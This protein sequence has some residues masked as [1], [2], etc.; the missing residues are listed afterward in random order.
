VAPQPRFPSWFLVVTSTR[1]SPKS[2]RVVVVGGG[3]AGLTAALELAEG[4]W[5]V[6]LLEARQKLGGRASS[7]EDDSSTD[8]VDLCQ[9]VA[10]GACTHT[11]ELFERIGAND[12]F[13]RE[14]VIHFVDET[15]TRT[16]FAGSTWLP[17][18]LH[19]GRAFQGLKFLSAS[20][21]RAVALGV[22]KL[23]RLSAAECKTG[24]RASMTMQGWLERI[25]QSPRVR[26]RF[27]SLVLVSALGETLDRAALSMG[28]KVFVEGFA[29][30]PRAYHV[31]IPTHSFDSLYEGHFVPAL[32]NRGVE[33][34]RKCSA[35]KLVVER[36]R[37]V[38]ME[39]AG[40]FQPARVVVVA[41]PWRK[42]AELLRPVEAARS[43]AE[44]LD[45][46]ESSAISSIHLWFDQRPFDLDQ[47]ALVG[48]L[49]QWFFVRPMTRED[50][51]TWYHVQSV[52]SASRKLLG[53]DRDDLIA[54]VEREVRQLSPRGDSLKL[55]ATRV[56]HQPDAVYGPTP[57]AM[58]NIPDQST[59]VRG[60][61]LAG[62]WTATGWPATMEG[63]IRSGKLAAGVIQRA[64]RR[65]LLRAIPELSPSWLMR[66]LTR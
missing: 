56:V 55:L 62:D 14:K 26:D 65:P 34:V 31:L 48:R 38:G 22:W 32:Q 54:E 13:R 35:Q 23:L 25:G 16:D 15:G 36:N 47:M 3:L 41:V 21:R 52:I 12:F 19:L 43:I 46:L 57:A 64:Y 10:M 6:T 39:T 44:R 24:A 9:H 1:S 27:W 33:I 18:P 63:A 7:F 61:V 20:E 53:R 51:S 2:K 8:A 37:V 28:R 30:H 45:L 11:I 17:A 42:A 49:S 60:L 58:A 50:G 59:P 66:L 4:G 40:G 29:A 5:P